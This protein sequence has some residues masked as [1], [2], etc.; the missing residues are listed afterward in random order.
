MNK[1]MFIDRD[2]VINIDRGHV[3]LKEDFEF[4]PGIFDLCRKYNDAGYL[5]V[6]FT[7][8]AGIA[9][10]IYTED[11]FLKLTD[12]MI[13]EFKKNGIIISKVCYCPHHPDVT[14]S[15]NCRKPEPG[16][17]LQAIEEFDLDIKE[18]ILIGDME[19]DLEAGR[20]AGIPES[21]LHLI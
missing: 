17:I 19:S 21:N 16:M 7:N 6:V 18:C 3:F 14:G 8:Q 2:G 1:A 12:W 15:C 9:K 20:R 11:A 5:I 4:S 13:A 10:G